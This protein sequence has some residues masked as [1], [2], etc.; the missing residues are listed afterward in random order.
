M[1]TKYKHFL[2]VSTVL[3]TIVSPI[4]VV[5]SCGNEKK[6]NNS[7]TQSGRGNMDGTPPGTMNGHG[8]LTAPYSSVVGNVLGDGENGRFDQVHYD[9][10]E[11]TIPA[12]IGPNKAMDPNQGYN[13]K[14]EVD[15]PEKEA[16][17]QER[18]LRMS[19]G[20]PLYPNMDAGDL[21]NWSPE[22]ATIAQSQADA[23]AFRDSGKHEI[24]GID[25]T[26]TAQQADS[27]GVTHTYKWTV[28]QNTHWWQPR[29]WKYTRATIREPHPITF[30]EKLKPTQSVYTPYTWFTSTARTGKVHEGIMGYED[31]YSL[32]DSWAYTRFFAPGGTSSQEWIQI[33][34]GNVIDAAHKNGTRVLG[35][36]N[37]TG[38]FTLNI[39]TRKDANG[40]YPFAKSLANIADFYG[41]DG[42]V[43]DNETSHTITGLLK[44]GFGDIEDEMVELQK[45][46]LKYARDINPYPTSTGMTKEIY[47]KYHFKHRPQMLSNYSHPWSQSRKTVQVS[48]LDMRP[49]SK[50]GGVSNPTVKY[51]RQTP[52]WKINDFYDSSR[53]ESPVE[54]THKAYD[55]MSYVEGY[56]PGEMGGLADL[57]RA[58]KEAINASQVQR[59][60]ADG[61]VPANVEKY[62]YENRYGNWMWLYTNEEQDQLDQTYSSVVGDPRYSGLNKTT[63]FMDPGKTS[64]SDGWQ[65]KSGITGRQP[66]GTNFSSGKG[67]SF[68]LWGGTDQKAYVNRGENGWRSQGLQSYL[69]TYRYIVDEYDENGTLLTDPQRLNADGNHVDRHIEPSNFDTKSDNWIGGSAL[70][71]KGKLAKKGMSF[72]NKLYASSIPIKS[73]DKFKMV[74]K[75]DSIT[76]ELLAWTADGDVTTHSF[77]QN[78]TNGHDQW[79]TSTPWGDEL[80]NR[81]IVNYA[82]ETT[83]NVQRTKHTIAPSS[84]TPLGNTGWSEVE[85]DLSELA[86]KTMMDFGVKATAIKDNF[87]FEGNLTIGKMA[88]EPQ[89]YDISQDAWK[90]HLSNL[91]TDFVWRAPGGLAARV[92]WDADKRATAYMTFKADN[93]WKLQNLTWMDARP[94]AYIDNIDATAQ[95]QNVVIVA[96]DDAYNVVS[97]TKAVVKTGVV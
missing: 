79:P 13:R 56:N 76:P 74:I 64:V 55:K 2:S 89:G 60:Y 62:K 44:P 18:L 71:Y 36:I 54:T 93:N 85:Y 87:E 41:F 35:N 91:T 58:S 45:A 21:W 77:Y 33:P 15:S 43:F 11:G 83:W 6:V 86:S 32:N 7:T 1:K 65:E 50:G 73:G 75:N 48:D 12:G 46:Y 95:T 49:Q 52:T 17:L 72:E 26:A 30:G 67:K 70:R 10:L 22:G 8:G 23:E 31:S 47:D 78:G 61:N 4:A 19:T 27:H 69:P 5:V 38:K 82:N 25:W 39:A 66:W 42:W 37:W 20:M 97:A 14:M 96:L 84:V 3:A 94:A 57:R 90:I 92:S 81:G 80:Y 16:V 88:F 9:S 59:D 53:G 40:D 24:T 68:N 34:D 63:G 29:D 51:D 28:G